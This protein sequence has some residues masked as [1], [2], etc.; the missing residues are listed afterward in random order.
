MERYS[1]KLLFQF[2][3][4]T[5]GRAN[6]RRTCEERIVVFRAR[7]ADDALKR[8]KKA[9]RTAQHQYKN[10]TGGTVHFE[11]VGVLDLQHLGADCEANEVWY[12]IKELVTPMERKGTLV[13]REDKLT[14]IAWERGSLSR[15]NSRKRAAR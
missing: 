12:D 5:Y 3:V 7:S 14:A 11:F 1:A 6:R 4:V 15:K 9:G 2:R 10:N 8:A 13:P